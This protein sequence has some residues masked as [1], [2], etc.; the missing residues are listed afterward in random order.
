[1]VPTPVP[2]L[3]FIFDRITSTGQMYAHCVWAVKRREPLIPAGHREEIHRYITEVVKRRG[4]K[5]I[6]IYWRS[7]A[8]ASAFARI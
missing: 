6:A 5:L 1:M 3:I 2:I 4:Q 7:C 8:H